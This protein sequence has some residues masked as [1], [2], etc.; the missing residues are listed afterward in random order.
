MNLE[1]QWQ[2][3]PLFPL[4][5]VLNLPLDFCYGNILWLSSNEIIGTMTQIE[6]YRLGI[7]RK[8]LELIQNRGWLFQFPI[9][10]FR[11]TPQA[12]QQ[13]FS[14]WTFKIQIH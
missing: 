13:T 5:Q 14:K 6:A 1:N 4:F 10:H 3:F 12:N 9:I 11:F 2:I 8:P 7:V